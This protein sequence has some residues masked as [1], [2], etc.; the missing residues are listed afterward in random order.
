MNKKFPDYRVTVKLKND[1]FAVF[2]ESRSIGGSGLGMPMG[3]LDTIDQAS[4]VAHFLQN[5]FHQCELK[6]LSEAFDK[7]IALVS[8]KE[9]P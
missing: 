3:E 4:T 9:Q 5:A 2:V 6:G 8:A 7:A 1:K